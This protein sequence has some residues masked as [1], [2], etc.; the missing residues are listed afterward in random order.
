MI[1]LA[2][3]GWTLDRFR[4]RARDS[5]E[6]H[7]GVHPEA[8]ARLEAR[9]HYIDGDYRDKATYEQLRKALGD[10]A[11]PLHYLAIP[12]AMF[13]TVVEGLAQ[14]QCAHH[15]RVVVETIRPGSRLR[16]GGKPDPSPVLP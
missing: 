15:A 7:A 11:H 4:A 3:S 2:K 12:P 6:K 13:E 10:A 8:F 1:G 5:L 16:A 14:N 9:L